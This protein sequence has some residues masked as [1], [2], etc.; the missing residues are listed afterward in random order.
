MEAKRKQTIITKRLQFIYRFYL[1]EFLCLKD[2][3]KKY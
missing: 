2:E 3:Y 1:K